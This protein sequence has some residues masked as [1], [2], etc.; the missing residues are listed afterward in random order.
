MTWLV[1]DGFDFYATATI[2]SSFDAFTGSAPLWTFGGAAG[3]TSGTTRFGVGRS[4]VPSNTGNIFVKTTG[5]NDPEVVVN[6]AWFYNAALGAASSMCGVVLGDGATAQCSIRMSGDGSLVLTTGGLAGSPLA[7]YTGAFVASTWVHFQVRIIVN[8]S[9]GSIRVRTNGA[10]SDSFSASP[11]NTRGGTSN[12]YTNQISIAGGVQANNNTIIDDFYAFNTT[13][14]IPND[15]QG[16]VRAVQSMV[17]SDPVSPLFSKFPNSGTS[18]SKINQLQ[19]DGDTTYIYDSVVNDEDDFGITALG[20]TPATIVAVQAKMF[21][22]KS[23][24]G[25]RSGDL[26]MTSNGTT[27]NFGSTALSTTYGYLNLP[28]GTDPHTGLAW[29][30]PAV[31]ALLVGPKVTA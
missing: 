31:D 17:A 2:N 14:T 3:L 22:K 29:T 1:G 23:D 10:T 16:D 11:L 6:F 27:A 15:W 21:V 9:T 4:V 5:S 18:F 13:G 7:T 8:S 24:S 28:E 26:I 25:S 12:N 30:Q 19:E 20:S